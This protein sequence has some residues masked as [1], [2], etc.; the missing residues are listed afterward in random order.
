MIRFSTVSK[1]FCKGTTICR[2][3]QV[4]SQ[5]MFAFTAFRDEMENKRTA[6]AISKAVLNILKECRQFLFH[7]DLLTIPDIEA[8]LRIIDS[9]ACQVVILTIAIIR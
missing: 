6:S 1:L 2:H 8:L 7:H 4:N 9:T 3:S 5:L